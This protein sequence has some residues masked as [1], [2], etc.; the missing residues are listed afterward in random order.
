MPKL[1]SQ[2]IKP[3]ALGF[4]PTQWNFLTRQEIM[5]PWCWFLNIKTKGIIKNKSKNNQLETGDSK[6]KPSLRTRDLEQQFS[7]ISWHPGHQW[8]L[9]THRLLSSTQSLIQEAWDGTREYAFPTSH[10]LGDADAACLRTTLFEPLTETILPL[11]VWCWGPAMSAWLGKIHTLSTPAPD[12]SQNLHINKIS[13][14]SVPPGKFEK[15][16]FKGDPN[17]LTHM[18]IC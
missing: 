18:H 13:K 5:P 11:K 7:N 15:H 12:L 2:P 3:K 1:H 8:G 6:D 17:H 16:C 9:I 4:K 10:W 14:W